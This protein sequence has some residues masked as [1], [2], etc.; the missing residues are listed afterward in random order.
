MD[1]NPTPE[2]LAPA[3]AHPWARAYPPGITW[4]IALPAGET[5]VS[6]FDA[7]VA[8]FADRPCLDFLGRRWTYRE[9]GDA[10]AR[11]AEGFRQLGVAPGA[12][13]GLCLPN[14]PWHVVAYFGALK[15]GAIVVNFS[16]L[17][18]E[19]EL[20]AQ[21]KDSGTEVMVAL[22]L[23]PIL[24]RAIKLLN[25]ADVPVRRVVA[26]RFAKALP[27][28]K[29]FLFSVAKRKTIAPIPRGDDRVVAF[30]ALLAAPPIAAPVPV[31]SDA[32]A[33][34]QYTGGTT[35]VPKGVM[36]THANLCANLRQME[37]W[38]TTARPG[39]ERMLAVIPFFHV[40]AMTVAMNSG[41]AMGAEIVMLPRFDWAMLKA[42]LTR[43][44]PTIFP[45]VPTLFKACLD[46]GA[47]R[48]ELA[49]VR[50]C[51][52]GGAPLPVAVKERFEALSGS[53]VVE[54]Y[55]LT[56]ASPVCFCNPFE[57]ENRTGTI[58]LPLP[59]VRAEIR[60]LEDPTRALPPG[61]KGEL[62][63]A[64]PNVMTGYWNRPE[65]TAAVLGADG[66]LRTGDVG[67]MDAEGY[68]QLVDR[69][70]D[71]ILVSGFNVYPRVVEEAIYRHPE[72]AAATVVAMPDPYRGEAPAAFVEPKPGA[73]LTAEEVLAF[74]KDKLNPVE[75]PR[76]V[77]IRP[78]LPRTMVGKLSKKELK[79]EVRARPAASEEARA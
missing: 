51:I 57:G 48:E 17:Y 9:V 22:D 5:L 18:V 16:P 15:A 52:S 54:G 45:G 64:G 46:N 62:C 21:A 79:E 28:L 23:D 68:V 41:I 70:K 53:T 4:D 63:L 14:C 32:V 67:I 74:L 76:L 26:C 43:T 49:S 61:E 7:A 42:T 36:L 56:E 29:G 12:R 47:T 33:V 78:S 40:F 38:F 19:E 77:E 60:R 44:R 25:R 31:A 73:T 66:F 65:D 2:T 69:I 71:L 8:R 10:V 13:V 58:G 30:D 59:G 20:A 37:A 3:A 55:G 27:G 50:Y 75:M 34:L 39:E 6:M 35:G 1:T 72:V 24:P 11:A